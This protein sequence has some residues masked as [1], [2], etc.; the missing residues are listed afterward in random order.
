[1]GRKLTKLLDFLIIGAQ[2]SGTTTLFRLLSE[3]PEIYV[4]PGKEIPFFTDDVAYTAG[5]DRFLGEFFSGASPEKLWGKA[6]PQYLCDRRASGRIVQLIPNAKLIAILREPASRALS[7]YRMSVRRGI[8]KRTFE[9]AVSGLLSPEA[10]Q[11]ARELPTG[12]DSETST[13]VVWGEYGRL[14][15]PYFSKFPKEQI[16]V[17]FLDDLEIEP[18]ITVDR[19]FEFLGVSPFHPPSIGRRFY[20][21]G[22]RER[23]AWPRQLARRIR[24]RKIWHMLPKRLRSQ[25]WFRYQE[26]NVVKEQDSLSSHE[27]GTV[28]RLYDHYSSDILHLEN[29]LGRL[30]PWRTL[31]WR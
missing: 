3:H 30:T 26:L 28:Q 7:H 18:E 20:E 14:L 8:E 1:L 6:T 21:G 22:T 10:L 29:M 5:L 11:A 2:K 9:E 27:Q 24:A 12:K 25:I 19:V 13:Y 16:V 31:D 4:P 17:L 23:F 15:D